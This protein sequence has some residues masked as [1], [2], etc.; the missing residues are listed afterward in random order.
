[1]PMSGCDAKPYPRIQLLPGG[2]W[3]Y[4][5]SKEYSYTI[6]LVDLKL[7]TTLR[8]NKC[9]AFNKNISLPDSPS[10]SF[11]LLPVDILNFFKCHSMSSN[12]PYITQFDGYNSYDDCEGFTIYYKLDG[13]DDK[14]ILAGNLTANCSCIRLPYYHGIYDFN[15]LLSPQYFVEWKL[16]DNCNK[17]HYDGGQCQT[18]KNNNFLCYKDAKATRS[19]LGLTV[20]ASIKYPSNSSFYSIS[21]FSCISFEFLFVILAKVQTISIL[22]KDD[23]RDKY[24]MLYKEKDE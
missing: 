18:D 20:G 2:D 7:Q 5:I 24:L 23:R 17:C 8:Q 21:E 22:T 3:Y 4:A 13:V 9:Q 11:K 1:M 14:D 15:Y 19:K 16:S 12:N 10:I 6:V